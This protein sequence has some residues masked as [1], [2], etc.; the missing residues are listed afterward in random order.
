MGNFSCWKRIVEEDFCGGG[1]K[2]DY[3]DI[4]LRP[5][6]C[7]GFGI[8][9]RRLSL[10][11]VVPIGV[12]SF[13]GL[14]ALLGCCAEGGREMTE[15]EAKVLA[16][17]KAFL[18][19]GGEVD[20]KAVG[21]SG[22]TRLHKAAEAGFVE[23]AELL[24]GAGANVHARGVFFLTPLHGAAAEGQSNMVGLLLDH[25]AEVAAG[26]CDDATPLHLAGGEGAAEVIE[27]LLARGA[28]IEAEGGNGER[29][30]HR[31]AGGDRQATATAL[32]AKGADIEAKDDDGCTPLL[33]AA[34]RK[35]E[36]MCELLISKG[37]RHDVFSASA[38]GKIDLVEGFSG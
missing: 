22:G 14:A 3:D 34:S 33:W 11:S 18:A 21:A 28:D 16:E 30:L 19:G 2:C 26:N 32:V 10:I 23:V 38:A 25:G 27:L 13:V 6:T 24:I 36:S 17:T 4:D 12:V 29:P 1:G 20:E 5:G 15:E 9:N 37:A 35:H 7:V 31:A 8:V